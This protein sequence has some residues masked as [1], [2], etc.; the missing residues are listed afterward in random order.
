MLDAL[1]RLDSRVP[2]DLETICLKCLQKEPGRRYVTAREL[3]EAGRQ[4]RAMT[5][6]ALDAEV[7]LEKAGRWLRHIKDD[8]AIALT[9]E[10]YT[11]LTSPG[12]NRRLDEFRNAGGE[13]S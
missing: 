7:I 11:L 6:A 12:P 13:D 9:K 1:R 5:K 3:A 2:R 10:C 8:H 4:A